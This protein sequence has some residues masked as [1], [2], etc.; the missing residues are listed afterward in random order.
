MKVAIYARISTSNKGQDV[1]NQVNILE[2][3]CNKMNYQVHKVYV[4]EMSGSTGTDKR[5]QNIN[6]IVS[7]FGL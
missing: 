5:L 4:D 7:F 6:L 2:D 3:Y 1:D